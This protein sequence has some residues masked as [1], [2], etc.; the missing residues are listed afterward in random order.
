MAGFKVTGFDE[1]SK[2]LNKIQKDVEKAAR[3]YDGSPVSLEKVFS[4]EFM[5]RNTDFTDVYDWL[6]HGGFRFESQEEFE[7]TDESL[8]DS[9]VTRSTKFDSWK[10][11]AG[12]AAAELVSKELKF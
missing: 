11:M 9:Y 3:K 2:A 4:S 5:E 6:E 10:D 1:F 12:E 7:S 8:L